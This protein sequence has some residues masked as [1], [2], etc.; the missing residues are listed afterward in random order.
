[1]CRPDH[2]EVTYCINP[3]MDPDAPVDRALALDQWERLRATYQEYGHK[4][5]V[6]PGVPGLPDMVFA[7]NGGLV[8]GDRAMSARFTHAER[9][10]EGP[11]YHRWFAQHGLAGLVEAGELNEGEGDFLLVG[12]KLL[13]GMGFRSSLAA[14]QEVAQHFSREVVSLELVDPRFYHLD[15]VLLPLDATTIAYFPPAFSAAS[16]AVL[17][18]LFPGAIVATDADAEVLGLNGVC[19]GFNVFLSDKAVTL[20]ESLRERGFNPVGIDM[21]EL[22]KAGGS[23]KCCTLEIH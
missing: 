4:I 7:A 22:L 6:V 19:D 9:A 13:A 14:H 17:A 8:I 18:E 15:T 12:D 23:V 11:A 10:A 3:W 21:S 2:F 16:Q 5:D 1:M 20:I